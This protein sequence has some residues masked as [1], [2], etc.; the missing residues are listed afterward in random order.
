MADP[1]DDLPRMGPEA[2]G[3]CHACGR[4]LLQTGLPLFYRVRVD[5]C[6]IDGNAVRSHVGL[7]MH[8][9]G[10]E[11][12]LVLASVL[13]PRTEPVVV[14]NKGPEFNI[15][16]ACQQKPGWMMLAE[17]ALAEKED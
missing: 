1:L 13:G 5:Q 16:A 9:G 12:G 3:P 6:G 10:G 4:Q 8:M 15:C 7:A 14:M 11:A 2:M 17:L